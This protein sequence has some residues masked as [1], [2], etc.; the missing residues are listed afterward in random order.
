M[1]AFYRDGERYALD[2]GRSVVKFALHNLGVPTLKGTLRPKA[3]EVI[4]DTSALVRSAD[5]HIDADS[6]DVHGPNA[7]GEIIRWLFGDESNPVVTFTTT[8]ARPIGHA[9]VELEGTLRMHGHDHLLSLRTDTGLWQPHASGAMWHR[10]AVHGVLDRKT[11]DDRKEIEREIA[12]LLLGHDL[13]FSAEFY[14]G[15][16]TSSQAV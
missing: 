3:G 9:A 4:V 5:F 10:S 11:W 16:K 14:A 6:I 15:P 7:A 1:A 13:H 8:W 12:T 2:T